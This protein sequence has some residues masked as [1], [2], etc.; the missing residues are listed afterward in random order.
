MALKLQSF[1]VL[2]PDAHFNSDRVYEAGYSLLKNLV[3]YYGYLKL[4]DIQQGI[5]HLLWW[6]NET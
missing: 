5:E 3:L 4:N 1:H 6:V 2:H